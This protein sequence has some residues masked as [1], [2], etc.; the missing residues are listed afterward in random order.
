MPY[1]HTVVNHPVYPLYISVSSYSSRLHSLTIQKHISWLKLSLSFNASIV[2]AELLCLQVYPSTWNLKPYMD[3][4]SLRI[5]GV[6]CWAVWYSLSIQNKI[7]KEK[8]GAF[9]FTTLYWDP[10]ILDLFVIGRQLMLFKCIVSIW[11]NFLVEL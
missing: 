6:L 2:D 9:Y 3:Y 11:N 10:V 5:E 1:D 7:L 8:H 4:K